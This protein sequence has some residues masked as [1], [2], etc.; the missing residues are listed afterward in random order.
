MAENAETFRIMGTE[1]MKQGNPI[2]FFACASSTEETNDAE[3]SK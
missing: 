3:P 2:E 1:L